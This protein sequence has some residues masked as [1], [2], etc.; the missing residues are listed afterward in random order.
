MDCNTDA[1]LK[2]IFATT[3]DEMQHMEQTMD[4]PIE[5]TK[6]KCKKC[7]RFFS[8]EDGL[9]QHHCEPPIKKEKCPH[10]GKAI[11]H[12]KYLE[13]QLRSCEKASTNPAKQQLHQMTLDG[14]T[15]SQNGPSMPKKLV[16]EEVKVGSGP[17][18]HAQHWKAPEIV[19]STLKYKAFTSRETFN[20]NNKRDVPQRLKD[21][22]RSMRPVTEGQTQANGET[23][24]WYLSLN[25]NFCK[26]TIPSINT[27]LAVTFW[28]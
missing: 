24:K 25:M 11:N 7:V 2:A 13:R 26:S 17:V 6:H 19:E 10:C 14:S 28:S 4:C 21:V 20:S 23:F 1:Q 16:V 8:N 15:S 9:R 27:D 22:I 18:K 3:D 5:R 12:A